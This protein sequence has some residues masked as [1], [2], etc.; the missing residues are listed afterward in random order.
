[1]GEKIYRKITT[2]YILFTLIVLLVI[3][4]VGL[5][6][7]S[8]MIL[9][10]SGVAVVA[11]CIVAL[12]LH[13]SQREW[14]GGY[15]EGIEDEIDDVLRYSVKNHPLPMCVVNA[16]GRLSLTNDRFKEAFPNARLIKTNIEE[17]IGITREGLLPKKDRTTHIVHVGERDYK[18]LVTF[19]D[20][21]MEKSVMLYFV[22]VT[23]FERLKLRYTYERKCIA[24]VLVD[25]Y[26]ELINRTPD[27]TRPKISG[28]IEA[29]IRAWASG[30]EGAI[31]KIRD[32]RYLIIFDNKYFKDLKDNKF[33][34]LDDVRAI[35]TDVD[36]PVSLSI[37]VG[38]GGE[39]P[40]V[41]EDFAKFAMDMAL[42]RGGDQAVVKSGSKVTYY[43]GKVQFLEKRNKGK[44]RVMSHA[45][46]QLIKQSSRVIIMGH[47]NPDMDSLGAALAVYRI[48]HTQQKDA[49]VVVN[50]ID[51]SM[52]DVFNKARMTG[53][54]RFIESEEAKQLL[55]TGTLLVVVD[56]H[57]PY[58]V[59]AKDLLG[60]TDKLVIIDH[61]RKKEGFIEGADLSYMDPNASSTS[62]LVTEIIQY[63][64]DIR[65]LNKFESEML[66][67]GIYVD[68]N[69]FSVK[70]GSRTFEAAAWLRQNGAETTTVRK[71]LQSDMEDFKQRASIITNAFYVHDN[72]AVSCGEG[73]HENAQIICAQAADELL[74]VK[75]I[76]ASFVIGETGNEVV[77]SARSLG[78][79][80]VQVI[81]EKMGGG[82]HLATAAAQIKG[83]TVEDVM[84][85]V[86]SHIAEAV[87]GL[88]S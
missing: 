27:E 23:S 60:H 35:E 37:G 85:E 77:I 42:G 58:M 81:L 88:A 12:V 46:K 57:V 44:S 83:R 41:T 3:C 71:Y 40:E 52:L 62:E 7:H 20:S 47:K 59:E 17:L 86:I 79:L 51:H 5:F 1:M 49:Y 6:A 13:Y 61:H 54:Y 18:V 32:N 72:I 11:F 69:G 36:F 45:L 53:N 74:G 48:A 39:S 30:L 25:N 26:D 4:V 87:D 68:T 80:N 76:I 33:S 67:G 75:G 38:L 78:E 15:I 2:P 50:H 66:L 14:I 24:Y 21:D 70:A 82:G 56:V 8:M 55:D 31:I 63:D 43:G 19:L 84:N 73:K 64:N 16:D 65:K 34:I 9:I 28:S 22:D 29:L 10:V